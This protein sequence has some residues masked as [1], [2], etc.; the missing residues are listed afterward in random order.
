ML[1]GLL[2]PKQSAKVD[3]IEP[4]GL[5]IVLALLFTGVLWRILGPAVNG[6][7]GALYSMAG[8]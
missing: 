8:F 7:G 3:A 2:P 1:S 6:L 5:I 4:Y